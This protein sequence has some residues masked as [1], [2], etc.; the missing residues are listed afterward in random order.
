MI[1]SRGAACSRPFV[2]RR[3]LGRGAEAARLGYSQ[4][5]CVPPRSRCRPGF[6][7]DFGVFFA[8]FHF[9]PCFCEY[10]F[11]PRNFPVIRCNTIQYRLNPGLLGSVLI[12]YFDGVNT[13]GFDASFP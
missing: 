10:F 4:R 1:K 3:R 8:L 6:Q 7:P 9:R 2:V 5:I 12:T 11:V 13:M